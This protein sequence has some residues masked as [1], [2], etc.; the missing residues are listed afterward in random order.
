MVTSDTPLTGMAGLCSAAPPLKRPL[1]HCSHAGMMALKMAKPVGNG[2][3]SSLTEGAQARSEQASSEGDSSHHAGADAIADTGIQQLA[4]CAFLSLVSACPAAGAHDGVSSLHG[5]KAAMRHAI[6]ELLFFAS[7]GDL[8]R[9]QRIC[10]DFNVQVPPQGA[11]LRWGHAR[12][13]GACELTRACPAAQRGNGLRPQDTA[14]R[15]RCAGCCSCKSLGVLSPLHAPQAP[16]SRRGV[17]LGCAVAAGRCQGAAKPSGQVLPDALG[18]RPWPRLR[19]RC[20]CEHLP[21]VAAQLRPR[22]ARAA[23]SATGRGD[24]WGGLQ[25]AARGDFGEV[26]RL[27]QQHG[28]LVYLEKEDKLVRLEDSTLCM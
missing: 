16:G 8:V 28:G 12:G 7:I 11:G 27:L 3:A 2:Q 1:H 14:V 21:G 10:K 23:S 9:F 24:A 20:T 5:A 6:T 13:L 17:P 22:Q 19:A 18:G 15:M 4:L 26:V 25:D